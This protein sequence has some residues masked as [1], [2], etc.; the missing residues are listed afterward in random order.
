MEELSARLSE[1]RE[2]KKAARKQV[3]REDLLSRIRGFFGM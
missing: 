3:K 1:S 2:K